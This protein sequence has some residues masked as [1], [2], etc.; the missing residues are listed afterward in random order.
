MPEETSQSNT[1]AV[2]PPVRAARPPSSAARPGRPAKPK[3]RTYGPRRKVCRLC[4]DKIDRIDYKQFQMLRTFT[5]DSGK[6]LS[7]RITGTCAKHQ[8]QIARAIKRNRNTAIM[9]YV[10]AV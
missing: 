8:R 1:A 5:A 2:R 9:P 7:S 4:A 10:S 3:R 6:M